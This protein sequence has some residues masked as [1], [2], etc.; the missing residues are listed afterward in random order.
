MKTLDA[1]RYLEACARWREEQVR[2]EMRYATGADRDSYSR[3]RHRHAATEL[4]KAAK[5]LRMGAR[6]LKA[7][8]AA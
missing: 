6:A 2:V 1:I 3:E 4:R 8:G 5:A 7:G